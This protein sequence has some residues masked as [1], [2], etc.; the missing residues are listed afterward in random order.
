MYLIEL[1]VTGMLPH[2]VLQQLRQDVVQR[3]WN[4]GKAGRHMAVNA[5]PWRVPVLMLTKPSERNREDRS[6]FTLPFKFGQTY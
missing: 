3:Q 6:T 4:K 1:Y 5:N 2:G